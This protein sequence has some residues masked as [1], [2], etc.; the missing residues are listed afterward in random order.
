MILTQSSL[1]RSNGE[2][3]V[4]A[5]QG[6]SSL[7]FM[8]YRARLLVLAPL[9]AGS[10][11]LDG[12]FNMT[13]LS[14]AELDSMLFSGSKSVFLLLTAPLC[15]SCAILETHWGDLAAAHLSSAKLLVAYV[16]CTTAFRK[17]GHGQTFL[18][19]H[20]ITKYPALR[21]F[22]PPVV[23]ERWV[24]GKT[25]VGGM[26]LEVYNGSKKFQALHAFA[27]TLSP[28]C[29]VTRYID[30]W[31]D[32]RYCSEE[33]RTAILRPYLQLSTAQLTRSLASLQQ[34]KQQ[35][36]AEIPVL[37][38]QRMRSFS[39][40]RYPGD[41]TPQRL[42]G[43]KVAKEDEAADLAAE[44]RKTELSLQMVLEKDEF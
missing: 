31:S 5:A 19:R 26:R 9:I 32:D 30:T 14:R 33:E 39:G 12:A 28:M 27:E 21:Y 34:Q 22:N 35:V 16:N 37:E 17:S 10:T 29:N 4:H 24:D 43:R 23:P 6:G 25:L 44:I 3:P 41:E 15:S 18:S 36:D 20:K 40:M 1:Q 8:P 42:M 13:G 7:V 38:Q 2:L 11:A